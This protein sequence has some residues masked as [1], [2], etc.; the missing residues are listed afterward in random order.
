MEFEIFSYAANL[1][2]GILDGEP[3][4]P[5]LIAVKFLERTN[6]QTIARFVNDS[7]RDLIP[8]EKFTRK[9]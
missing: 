2:I 3:H 1:L 6:H 7:L 9:P 8:A 5:L 4:K